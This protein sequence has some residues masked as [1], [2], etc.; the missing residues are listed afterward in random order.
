MLYKVKRRY[1]ESEEMYGYMIKLKE[2]Y[3]G[4]FSES[5]IPVLKNIAGVQSL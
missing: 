3:Y 5:L 4:E 2:T 1:V